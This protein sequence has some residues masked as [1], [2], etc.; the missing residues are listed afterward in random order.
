MK[1]TS[2]GHIA[3]LVITTVAIVAT[4]FLVINRQF[5]VDQISVWRYQPTNQLESLVAR[6]TMNDQGKFYLYASQ[7][8]IESAAGFNEKCDRKEQGSAIL[9]CYTGRN[10]YIYN[11]TDPKLDGIREVTIAH[12]TLHA[13]YDRLDTNE[14][15]RVNTLLQAEYVKIKDDKK[16]AERV[17]FYQ[18]T[19]PGELNNE[20]HSIIGTEIA[21]I[22]PELESYYKKYF[23]DR[24]RVAQLYSAYESI[25]NDL[26]ARSD[27]LAAQLTTL[28]ATIEAL[29]AT[30][31]ADVNQLNAD[32]AAFNA[33]ADSG[34]FSSQS[35]F[36]AARNALIARSDQLDATQ[37][38]INEQIA[39]YEALRKELEDIAIQTEAL[40]RSI[41]S[42][43]APAPSL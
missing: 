35:Q 10:I 28:G 11:I 17:E 26:S 32:I 39:Q 4:M 25:F 8:A 23:T 2:R 36:Q 31:N 40:N 34:G 18:R 21:L 27:A 38:S 41:D 12:E 37:I 19:E 30:Y 1:R 43:L 22:S 15:N 3:T 24:S 9:G 33:K 16:F 29:S 14:K 20:L 42:T 13:A 6:T 7:P 5:V